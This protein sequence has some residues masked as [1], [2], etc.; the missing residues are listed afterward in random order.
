M[1]RLDF[2]NVEYDIDA[3][4][5]TLIVRY[6]KSMTLNR[7]LDAA[8]L[9]VHRSERIAYSFIFNNIYNK[10]IE[11]YQIGLIPFFNLYKKLA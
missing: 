6:G 9:I 1:S 4:V 8:T 11:L 2:V 10:V 3:S 7:K 5:L